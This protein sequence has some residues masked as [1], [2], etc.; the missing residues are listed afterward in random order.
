M[1][2][3]LAAMKEIRLFILQVVYVPAI[4]VTAVVVVHKLNKRNSL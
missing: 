1:S 4:V 2:N 3:T